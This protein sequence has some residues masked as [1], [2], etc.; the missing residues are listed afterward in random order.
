MVMTD[1]EKQA[2]REKFEN[3][4]KTVKCPRCGDEIIYEV[5]GNSIAVEC[6]KPKCIYGGMRGL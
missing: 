2:L 3:P 4:E 5:R 6:K 1:K